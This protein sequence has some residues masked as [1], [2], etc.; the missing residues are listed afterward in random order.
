MFWI[1]GTRDP[2]FGKMKVSVEGWNLGEIDVKG[3]THAEK[4]V[5]FES[6]PFNWGRKHINI[7]QVGSAPIAIRAV[8]VMDNGGIGCLDL[9]DTVYSVQRGEIVKIRVVRFAG[10]KKQTNCTFQTYPESAYPGV[11]YESVSMD[12]LFED[13]E[14]QKEI[15]IKTYKGGTGSVFRV[16]IL[17]L[18][19]A[20][21][22]Y[23]WTAVVNILNNLED[24]NSTRIYWGNRASLVL[25]VYMWV[26][27]GGVTVGIFVFLGFALRYRLERG[28]M[29]QFRPKL[30]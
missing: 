27:R 30:W 13:Y 18:Q 16:E 12:V 2:S 8:Y 7:E 9:D 1:I 19:D 29:W 11:D 22:G 20:I 25:T 6:P 21:I 3:P 14:Q 4:Q 23:K 17:P 24:E 10:V 28:R 15:T 26:A 5:L